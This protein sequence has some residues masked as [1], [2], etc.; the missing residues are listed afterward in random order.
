M[1]VEL[2][3]TTPHKQYDDNPSLKPPEVD[4]LAS[5]VLAKFCS[6][7]DDELNYCQDR[8]ISGKLIDRIRAEQ[9]DLHELEKGFYGVKSNRTLLYLFLGGIGSILFWNQIKQ[10]I[11]FIASNFIEVMIGS[12]VFMGSFMVFFYPHIKGFFTSDI[13]KSRPLTIHPL[14]KI[15]EVVGLIYGFVFLYTQDEKTGEVVAPVKELHD[16][17]NTITNYPTLFTL[18]EINRLRKCNGTISGLA[19]L[20]GSIKITVKDLRSLILFG[21][22]EPGE[23]EGMIDSMIERQREVYGD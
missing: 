10:L 3:E 18:L 1:S 23:A 12:G 21:G 13:I 9:I 5:I 7:L 15:P 4:I 2:I 14:G 16:I 17:I 8:N 19:M 20:F 22:V 6:N 11:S